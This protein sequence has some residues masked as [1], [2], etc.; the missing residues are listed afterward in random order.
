MGTFPKT[1]SE[2]GSLIY[3]VVLY[4]SKYGT[5]L[6]EQ[7]HIVNIPTR[8]DDKE[9]FSIHTGFLLCKIT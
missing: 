4:S 8:Q 2:R 6:P 1:D 5:V 3:R 7:Q 9:K